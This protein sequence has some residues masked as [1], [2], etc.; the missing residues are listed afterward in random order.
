MKAE[1]KPIPWLKGVIQRCRNSFK[2]CN[3]E[4]LGVSL[5]KPEFKNLRADI[6]IISQRPLCG[7]VLKWT[8]LEYIILYCKEF[9]VTRK[10]QH[11]LT[12][13]SPVF[14]KSYFW[15][16]SVVWLVKAVTQYNIVIE[17]LHL[18]KLWIL[19]AFVNFCQCLN[20]ISNSVSVNAVINNRS[21]ID[22]L[23]SLKS[24]E[25]LY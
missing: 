21:N 19:F 17:K 13:A 2:S 12:A 16:C 3:N 20:M 14:S 23:Y 7:T 24:W 9:F 8:K 6:P 1:R 15:G 11:V 18:T 22:L 25:V 4:N 5:F 10:T